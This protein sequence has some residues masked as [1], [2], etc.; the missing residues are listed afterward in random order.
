MREEIMMR[1]LAHDLR[2]ALR[3]FRRNPAFTTVVVVVLALGIGA[4]SAMFSVVDAVVLRPLPYAASDELLVV[5]RGRM[6]GMPGRGTASWPTF[7][8]WRS[9]SRSVRD[10]AAYHGG[11]LALTG[12]AVPEL[13]PVIASTANLFDLLGVRPALGRGFVAGE[14]EP[15]RNRVVVLSDGLWRRRFGADPG[16]IGR[17]ITLDGAPHTIIGVA[18]PGFNFPPT[19]HGG[20]LWVPVPQGNLDVHRHTRSLQTLQVVGRL[21]AGADLA[22]AQAELRTIDARLARQHP[23]DRAAPGVLTATSLQTELTGNVRVAMFTLLAA[24]AAVLLIA[25]ANVANLLLARSAARGRE[26]AV[27]AALGAGRGRIVRQLLTESACLGILGGALGL[28]LALWG[29]DLLVS[30]IPPTVARPHQIAVDGRVLLFTAVA[31]LGTSVGF[32][33]VPALSAS[34]GG[35]RPAMKLRGRAAI[36]GRRR[37][38]SALLTAEIAISFLLLV[39]AGLALRSFARVAAVDP[40]FDSRDLVTASISLPTNRYQWPEGVADFY[41]RLLPRVAALPGVQGAALAMPLPFS[42]NSINLPFVVPGRPALNPAQRSI[43]PARFVSPDYF[44]VLGIPLVRGRLLQPADDLPGGAPVAVVS[45]SFAR[46]H[47][48]GQDAVGKAVEVTVAFPGV[49]RIVGVV[50]DVRRR[51]DEHTAPQLYLSFHQ[52]SA[53]VPLPIRTLVVRTRAGVSAI[54]PLRAELASMDAGLPLGDVK[55]MDELLARS[56]QQRRLSATLLALF[57]G[58]ALLLAAAGIYGVMSYTVAQQTRELGLRMALG[59]PRARVLRMVLGQGLRLGLLG[60][61]L[62]LVAA[63]AFTRVLASQLYEVSATD[64]PTFIVIAAFLLAVAA[65]ATLLPARR[66]TRVDPAIAL[67][68]E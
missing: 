14:D 37:L 7:R 8:D 16:M 29:L 27:R 63:L 11:V 10:M 58:L 2:F 23:E 56:L 50:R 53:Q 1:T 57:A 31:A 32:G 25:C 52:P 68:H 34:A 13:I 4:N 65:L 18:D 17:V 47:F 9:H 6:H 26:L 12:G 38:R 22:T 45:E 5:G 39:G 43:S 19:E 33:I 49:R 36:P 42:P 62:G 30:L 40:G 35:A 64:P 59:A 20:Q 67:S 24:V 41:R 44:A 60:L 48:P 61:A 28:A 21:A 46:L 54:A 3:S 66:A 51:L 55:T 15:G